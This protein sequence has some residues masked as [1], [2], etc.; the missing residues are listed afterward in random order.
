MAMSA[1]S[2]TKQAE[3]IL[4][5]RELDRRIERVVAEVFGQADD[6]AS[7]ADQPRWIRARDLVERMR[8]FMHSN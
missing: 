4:T 1:S 7:E 6:A 2:E 8:P 5:Q 3:T